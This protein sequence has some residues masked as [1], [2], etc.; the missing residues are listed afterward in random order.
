MNICW[1]GSIDLSKGLKGV[2]LKPDVTCL[3]WGRIFFCLYIA[4]STGQIAIWQET[5]WERGGVTRSE[6]KA[7]AHGMP[8]LPTELNSAPW[9]CTILT[10]NHFPIALI[11]RIDLLWSHGWSDWLETYEAF[12][13]KEKGKGECVTL[14]TYFCGSV[15]EYYYIKSVTKWFHVHMLRA[16]LMCSFSHSFP[17]LLMT[18]PNK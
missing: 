10:I 15:L 4:L 9:G 3:F 1:K 16:A 6:D 12:G 17:P 11:I 18:L 14:R 2:M 5:G 7:S 13:H 8:T